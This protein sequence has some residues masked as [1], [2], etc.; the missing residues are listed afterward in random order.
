MRSPSPLSSSARRPTRTSLADERWPIAVSTDA[1]SSSASRSGPNTAS[2]TRTTASCRRTSF[3]SGI[4]WSTFGTSVLLLVRVGTAPP[5]RTATISA[6]LLFRQP[7]RGGAQGMGGGRLGVRYNLADFDA[8][9]RHCLF[10]HSNLCRN[11]PCRGLAVE[12]DRPAALAV[13]Q[14]DPVAGD[15]ARCTALPRHHLLVQLTDGSLPVMDRDAHHDCVHG[16]LLS[17]GY[18]PSAQREG[19]TMRAREASEPLAR[20]V[21]ASSP[22]MSLPSMG[23]PSGL[24]RGPVLGRCVGRL[25]RG[26]DHPVARCRGIG[27]P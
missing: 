14:R 5:V 16:V 7:V 18:G 20:I 13:R 24:L 11:R 1:R 8:V 10:R 21:L 25:V 4:G 12:R 19:E 27:E 22:A 15:E 26:D 23:P 6:F 9:D 3:G 17:S 2:C